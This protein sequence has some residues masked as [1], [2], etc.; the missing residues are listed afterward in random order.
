MGV[1]KDDHWYH[2]KMDLGDPDHREAFL[3]GEVPEDLTGV[4]VARARE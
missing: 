3:A 2:F 1:Y 4:Q